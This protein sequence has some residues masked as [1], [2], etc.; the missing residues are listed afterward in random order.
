MLMINRLIGDTSEVCLFVFVQVNLLKRHKLHDALSQ[1]FNLDGMYHPLSSWNVSLYG[2][3]T[4]DDIYEG[5]S[6]SE[7]TV[8]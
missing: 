8:R 4:L 2:I 1:M 3:L 7:A 5:D 6:R